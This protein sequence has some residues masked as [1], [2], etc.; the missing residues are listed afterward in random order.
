MLGPVYPDPVVRTVTHSLKCIHS[1]MM[2][3]FNKV[4]GKLKIKQQ[5][6]QSLDFRDRHIIDK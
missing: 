5:R 3:S 6:I 4:S 1:R 2:L